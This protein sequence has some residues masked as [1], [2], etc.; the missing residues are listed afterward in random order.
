MPNAWGSGRR[1]T[2]MCGGRIVDTSFGLNNYVLLFFVLVLFFILHATL[3]RGVDIFEHKLLGLPWIVHQ[4]K[5]LEVYSTVC[6]VYKAQS[7]FYHAFF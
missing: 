3:G 2:R 4:L 1:G 5:E 7:M 6:T